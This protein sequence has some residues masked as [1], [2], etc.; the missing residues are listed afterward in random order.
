MGAEIGQNEEMGND[1]LYIAL[2]EEM[3][4]NKKEQVTRGKMQ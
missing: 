2:L 4:N 1:G 3:G